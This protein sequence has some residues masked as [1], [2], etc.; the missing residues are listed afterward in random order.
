MER[1]FREK[2]LETQRYHLD[3]SR[4]HR[5]H[6]EFEPKWG[7]GFTPDRGK[8]GS[9]DDGVPMEAT[10]RPAGEQRS[11]GGPMPRKER[12]GNKVLLFLWDNLSLTSL[13]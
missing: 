12:M 3:E 10:E 8:K 9:Q 1:R 11:A 13:C 7:K 4:K 2:E 5:A 6:Y